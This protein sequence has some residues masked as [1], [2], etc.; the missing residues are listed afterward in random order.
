MFLVFVE[1]N[2]HFKW[3]C[4]MILS[5]QNTHTFKINRSLGTQA[6]KTQ[7][8]DTKKQF[9]FYY[10]YKRNIYFNKNLRLSLYVSQNNHCE[11]QRKAS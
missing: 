10:S 7:T 4:E 6:T 5:L 3:Y 8:K 11:K 2:T 9:R 1:M